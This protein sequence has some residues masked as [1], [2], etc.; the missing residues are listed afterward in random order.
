MKKPYRYVVP[1]ALGVALSACST[2]TTYQ[3]S[4]VQQ[5]K[6]HSVP[7]A[8]QN[9]SEHVSSS[10][11]R[12]DIEALRQQLTENADRMARLTAKLDDK[13]RQ[14]S[15]LMQGDKEASLLLQMRQIEAERDALEI[16]YN[17]LRLENDR[18]TAKIERLENDVQ[19]AQQTISERQVDFMALNKS[20]RTL[21]SAHFALSKDYRDLSVE[22]AHLNS[23]YKM[24]Q[25]KNLQ[26]A[27]TL[28]T[29]GQENLTLGG[30]L[31]EARAQHQ[32]LWDKI[33][34]QS[35]VIDTLQNQNAELHRKGRLVIAADDS[36]PE[37]ADNS[38][39][40]KAK[41]VRLQAELSAQNNLISGYQSDVVKLEAAL[42]RQEDDLGNQLQSLESTYQTA[43][44]RN[45][46][47]ERELAQLKQGLASQ[48][49][50]AESLAQ[51]LQSS[52][53]EKQQMKA[54][55]AE[56]RARNDSSAQAIKTLQAQS[57]VQAE[58]KALL[59]NQVN[60]LI[61]FE[62]AVLS[63]Q[64][65]LKSELTNVRWSLP[66]SANLHDT[67]EIQLSADVASPVQGQT[68]YAEL[69]V[70]SALNMMSAAEAESTLNQGQLN[71]R[72][73]LSGLNERPNA[74]MNVSVTQEVNY[75]GEIILRKIYRDTESVEL[76]STDWFNKYG[77]W[78]A[79]ILGG[80]LLGFAVGKLGQ[81]NRSE[82]RV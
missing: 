57:S 16:Q 2:Q 46:E 78:G 52:A 34:V 67:F 45:R 75:D 81:S 21:D 55:L 63:L 14:L 39:Q 28:D 56:L 43:A 65:Q 71:F 30:A 25:D 18:L 35:N 80:L 29:L 31:S 12:S 3:D 82:R 50:K 54:Q 33:R 9:T 41:V 70:D 60:N 48:E 17:Q 5:T 47:L 69:F 32:V 66:T 61:P 10:D 19:I 49:T 73:R 72:W 68:Y 37:A 76:I 8:S 51:K 59:E 7:A 27:E 74:T 77:F 11:H 44:Q 53:A 79:A 26:L 42:Q 62:G 1:V 13:D 58:E 20:F 22:H 64:N 40:L 23:Q 24:L 36:A 4:A 38:A 15:Q 6:L